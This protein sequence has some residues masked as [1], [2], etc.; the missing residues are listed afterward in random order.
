MDTIIRMLEKDRYCV[1]V[2]Q[3][4][5]AAIGL[6]RSA[7]EKLLTNHLKT[8]FTGGMGSKSPAKR[9]KMVGEIETLMKL[10]NK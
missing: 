5:L 10:Y 1:E 7:H 2:M 3:Q 8:C 4:N 6:L 9:A